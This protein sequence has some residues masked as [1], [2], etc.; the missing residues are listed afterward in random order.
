MGSSFRGRR[1]G[2]GI[3]SELTK[4]EEPRTS[5]APTELSAGGGGEV[6]PRPYP[7]LPLRRRDPGPAPAE[8]T[9]GCGEGL[10]GE[11]AGS[12]GA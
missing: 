2:S 7:R 1:S 9:G 5:A 3:T 4:R 8:R 6:T 10:C 12:A 11:R